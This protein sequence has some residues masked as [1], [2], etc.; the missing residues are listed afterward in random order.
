MPSRDLI[1]E[2]KANTKQALKEIEE[3][4]REIKSFSEN[5]KKGDISLKESEKT[6][7]SFTKRLTDMAHAYVGFSAVKGVINV[8]ADFEQSIAKLGAISGASKENLEKLKQKAEE[9][10]KSTQFSASQVAEGM[11]YLAMAGYKTKDIMASIGDVLNLAQVGMIDLAQASDIASNIL[12]GF[13][14]SADETKRVV[15]VM[16][17][18]I[19]N[20]NTNIPEMG[21]AMKMVA[22]QARAL[23]ISIEETST[24]LGIL[25]NNGLKG[26]IAGTGLST[27]LLRLSA[28]TGAAADAI[29]KLGIKIYDANGKF[30]GLTNVLK[31]F[32][33][34]MAGMSQEMKAKY[35]RDIFGIETMKT[36]LT[37]ID[38]VG[39]SYDELYKKVANSMGIS[40]KKAKQM[41]DTFKGH[42]K[43]L[44]SA[45]EGL[46]ITIG[47]ELL[48]ALTDFV[49][50]L[51]QATQNTEEFYKENKELINIVAKVVF[52]IGKMIAIFATL[53][54]VSVFYSL[55]KDGVKLL[56]NLNALRKEVGLL[57]VAFETLGKAN[58][59]LLALTAAIEAVNYAMDKWEERIERLEKATEILKENRKEFTALLDEVK[60]H[61]DMSEGRREI[62]MT[63]E[64]L[65]K[66]KD[67]TKQLIDANNKRIEKMKKLKE[68]GVSDEKALQREINVLIERNKILQSLYKKL[69]NTKPYKNAKTSAN[70]AKQAVEKLTQQQQKYLTNLD[71][72]LQ[73]EKTTS[74]TILEL[75]D[76]ELKKAEKI[77]G[78]TK[79]Y[80]EAKAKI[81]EYYNLQEIN[82]FKQVY[83][84][85]IS[86]HETLIEKLKSKEQ[87]LSNRILQIQK[88]LQEK[89]KQLEN[90]RLLAIESIE[91]KIH[92]IQMSGAT[93]YQKYIDVKK[94]A[95]IAYA[96]AKENLEKGNFE[97][98]RH[99]MQQY[100]RL[101]SSVANKE[102]KENAQVVVS[103]QEANN[104]AVAGLKKLEELTNAYYDK[105]KAK[106]IEVHNQKIRQLQAELTATKAQL[107]LE[108]QR[109]NLEKQM[110]ELLTGKKVDI[111]TTAALNAI[112][113]LD[114]EIKELDKKIKEP[115]KV[116]A[117]TSEAEK[118][119]S[120]VNKKIDNTKSEIKIDADTK[121]ALAAVLEIKDKVTG[122]KEV[123]KLY[124]DN[125]KAK[126]KINEISSKV[127]SLK[128][129]VK[130]NSDISNA[131]N[132]LNQIPKVITTIHYIKTVETHA[133]GGMAGF[134]RVSGKIPGDDPRNSDD[135]PALLT[136]GE[137]VIKRDAVK[138]YGEDFLYKLNHKILPKFATGGI[139]Q[140]GNPQKITRDL[141]KQLEDI[142]NSDS[143]AIDLSKIDELINTLKD[144]ADT[145][146]RGGVL[147]KSNDA[148]KLVESLKNEKDKI[149]KQSEKV[150]KDEEEYNNFKN[151]VKGKVLTQQQQKEFEANLK[152]K[153]SVIEIDT[154]KLEELNKEKQ[155]LL[156]NVSD[157]I[158]E[159]NNY[160]QEVENIKN[161]ISNK[162]SDFGLSAD[163]FEGLEESLNLKRLKNFYNHLRNLKTL[164]SDEVQKKFDEYIQ[165]V[166]Q[167]EREFYYGYG[168]IFHGNATSYFMENL[169]PNGYAFLENAFGIRSSKLAKEI[170][171]N[172]DYRTFGGN[173][174]LPD[175]VVRDILSEYLKKHLPKF[176]TGGLI[177]L[178]NGGKL[179]GYGGGDRNLALLEDGEFVIRKEAVAHFGA[180]LFEKLN[181]LKLPKFQTG[182]Y[183]GNLNSSGGVKNDSI[184]LNFNI[185]NKS[186]TLNAQ[187]NVAEE[188]VS[189]LK[190]LI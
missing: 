30:V 36:A 156:E 144:L 26:T 119:V 34:K 86:A 125:S 138:Y 118:K 91:S 97:L 168:S 190:K 126:R 29:N 37:L 149:S 128:P 38:S 152:S 100:E 20:A 2:I 48:P 6:L 4:K 189:E 184:D 71:K 25:A 60:K 69:Q 186:Y 18:T 151:S 93:D 67:R 150:K 80:E 130:V 176:Q 162:L 164:N 19:T 169:K 105:E 177:A 31:Q 188:L 109:L 137:F 141:S 153:K 21:E 133:S 49:K 87:D 131:L 120:E 167:R 129:S 15:D 8:V 114:K 82:S 110:I 106:A 53:K 166:I 148:L 179:P 45:F 51:T 32:K 22:P 47:N 145:F 74:K 174:R 124:A 154:K 43:E 103:K 142:R 88:E 16:T 146:K 139:V 113:N 42:M 73:K 160:L 55:T 17:A 50:W 9:L 165:G 23:G 63:A 76:E 3:L 158:R 171:T 79:Y 104:E 187:R 121:P 175:N 1:I 147:D 12:S 40:E 157:K 58:I 39:N 10:G 127:K 57:A 140:R 108:V 65:Q 182:G 13:G 143:N 89:L 132:K 7:A 24:A 5:V 59:V 14:L 172:F 161:K 11:N 64:E 77:L 101:I 56:K 181:N 68:E 75:R 136:R 35:M 81:I 183:V 54:K 44:E 33:E 116:N 123:I 78:K 170:P 117:D 134:K 84:K 70:E 61:M 52:E 115:K 62:K 185:G 72:R 95:D 135:V 90:S 159:F 102:I 155:K 180:D 41:T 111:D 98:A 107:E 27:M 66:L 163:S 85:R 46:L 178:Q 112:K 99:Y 92:S 94:Q 83:Q 173:Y 122:E 28:P 96:K